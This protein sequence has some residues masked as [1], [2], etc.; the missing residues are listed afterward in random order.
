M[1]RVAGGAYVKNEINSLNLGEDDLFDKIINLKFVR[2]KGGSFTIRSDYEAVH[3][4][5]NTVELVPCTQKPEIKVTYRQVAESVAIEVDI[6]V[7]NLFICAEGLSSPDAVNTADGDPVQWCIIQMGYRS[8]FPNLSKPK[9]RINV[10]QFYDL[11]NNALDEEKSVFLGRQIVVQILTGYEESYPPD[12]ITYFKGIVGTMET[13]LYWSHTEADLKK[14][15]NIANFPAK[16]SEIEDAAF[17]FITCR[18]VRPSVLHNIETITEKVVTESGDEKTSYKQKLNVYEYVDGEGKWHELTPF[19]NG[20]MS[21]EIAQ[22]IGILCFAS[23]VLKKKS[24]Y[25]LYTYGLTG[26]AARRAVGKIP[27]APYDDMRT[28]V[29]AQLVSLQQH[30]PFL[31]WYQLSDGNYYLYHGKEKD[32]DMW[33]DPY[34]KRLQK[35]KPVVLPAIYDMTPQGTRTIRCPFIS[36]LSPMQTVLFQSRYTLGSLVSFFYPP[37][38]NAFLVITAEIE[39]STTGEENKMTLLCVDL[40]MQEITLDENTGAIQA[41]MPDEVSEEAQVG[42]KENWR[43][44]EQ[45]LTVVLHKTG[46]TDTDSSWSNIVK[47]ELLDAAMNW[48]EGNKP[49]EKT[50]LEALKEW[51]PDYFDDGKAYMQRGNSIENNKAGIGG[52]CNI[53]VPWL[54]TGDEIIVRRPFQPEYP[55]DEK[56]AT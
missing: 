41:V 9:R 24:A 38:T 28:S 19:G 1:A 56:A 8:Q 31:R 6:R 23:S 35:E 11:N 37:K 43:W 13:G 12:K 47:K 40:P 53:K 46:A 10:N 36:F 55:E 45:T 7:T 50:A 48:V 42:E 14:G 2:K 15:Y 49:T 33:A 5:D 30:Y 29:G 26:E 25:A 22:K 20:V 54:K 21:V 27:A 3:H 16:Q 34:V 44:S 4:S 32:T 39:F 17:M 52:R 18:F 51:N